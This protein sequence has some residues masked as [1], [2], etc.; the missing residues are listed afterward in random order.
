MD[1]RGGV[2]G[3]GSSLPRLTISACGNGIAEGRNHS[4]PCLEGGSARGAAGGGG[5][6][7]IDSEIKKLDVGRQAKIEAR[8]KELEEELEAHAWDISPA[9]AQ[10]KIDELNN[11][12]ETL[13]KALTLA[14]SYLFCDRIPTDALDQI[15]HTIQQFK[16]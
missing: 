5:R 7:D 12:V 3:G 10:A 9:M 15:K 4:A 8:V 6:M 14:E 11:Q 2:G 13:V 1:G 16:R